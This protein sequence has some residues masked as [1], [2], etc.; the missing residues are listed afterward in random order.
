MQDSQVPS[1]PPSSGP[2]FSPKVLLILG[3]LTIVAV[4][5]VAIMVFRGERKDEAVIALVEQPSPG[6]QINVSEVIDA[7]GRQDVPVEIGR[8]YRVVID[9]ESRDTAA[10]VAH[11]GGLVTFVPGTRPGDEVVIEISRLKRS[12]AEAMVIEKLGEGRALAAPSFSPHRA[13]TVSSGPI[14]TGVVEDVGKKGDGIVRVDG[15][16]VFIPSVRAGERVVFQVVEDRENH[17][18]GRLVS[19]EE[20][21]TDAPAATA[22]PADGTVLEPKADLVQPGAVFDVK[23]VE[24]SRERPGEEGVARIEGLVVFVSG[25]RPGD[26]VR[27]RIVK[28]G[29]R[30]AAAEIVERLSATDAVPAP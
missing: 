22:P 13:D 19:R 10:G 27:I 14:H 11:I 26:D 5:A 4:A 18:V 12:T 16:V 20:G 21:G 30:Y 8:R 1:S 3:V 7:V 2:S 24:E 25:G 28:R 6:E 17:A 15:K 23:V 9:D 29:A